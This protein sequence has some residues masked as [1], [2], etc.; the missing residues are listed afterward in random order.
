VTDRIR[1]GSIQVVLD[2]GR[3][4]ETFNA[5]V[6]VLSAYGKVVLV[7][8]ARRG[9]EFPG[10]HREDDESCRETAAREALEE[11]GATIS[12]IEYLGYYVAPTGRIAVITCAKA[13]SFGRPDD[14]HGVSGVGLFDE[15]PADL[16]FGDGREQMFLEYAR[17][18]DRVS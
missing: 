5:V 2:E 3:A 16:S 4:A 7:I 8:N 18:R 13:A 10:G 12:D 1:V 15:L 9:W 6:V 17:T 14:E 11:A